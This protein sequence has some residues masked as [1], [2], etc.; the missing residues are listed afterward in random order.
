[1]TGVT[2][3]KGRKD[4]LME[5]KQY[6]SLTEAAK[7]KGRSYWMLREA[8]LRGELRATQ[9]TPRGKIYIRPIDLETYFE[10]HTVSPLSGKAIA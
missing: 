4:A 8:V 7:A 5:H 9:F 2:R 1:V 3:I 6:L 10:A